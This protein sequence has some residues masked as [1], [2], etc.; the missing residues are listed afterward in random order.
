MKKTIKTFL[1]ALFCMLT[2]STATTSVFAASAGPV[3]KVKSV[4]TTSVT[5]YWTKDSDAKSYEIQRSTDAKNW[6]TIATGIK[7]TEYTDSKSL[8]TGKSYAYRVR[9]KY[10][11]SYSN[12]SS[13]VVG[14]PVPAKVTGVKVKSSNATAIQLTWNK[15]AGASGYT[16]QFLSGSKWKTYKS[17]SSNEI[18]V[19]GVK[20]GTTYSF[21]VAAVKVVSG[22]WIYGPVSD[23]L[24]AA[25]SLPAT[26]TVALGG[27]NSTAMK[28]LWA[29]VSGAKGFEV[30]NH[31]TKEW[32]NAGAKTN[33]IISGLEPGKKYSFSVRAYAGSVK[34]KETSIFTWQTTPTV[35]QNVTITN[36]TTNTISYSWDP[37]EGASGYQPAYFTKANGKW[38]NLPLTAGTNVTVTGLGSMEDCGFRVRAFVK[39]SNVYNIN[40]YAISAYSANKVGKTVLGAT[41]VSAGK[42][43]STTSTN[44]SWKALNGAQSYV[45]E[46]YDISAK[47]WQ[48]YDFN[49]NKWI[50]SDSDDE[51]ALITT[52]ALT[53]TDNGKATRSDVYR[54]RCVDANGNLGTASNEVTASTSDIILGH[55]K[56]AAYFAIEQQLT[57]PAVDDAAS[58]KVLVKNPVVSYEEIDFEASKVTK[59]NGTCKANL[60]L[61]PKSTHSIMVLCTT[62]DGRTTTA[63]SWLTFNIGDLVFVKNTHEYYNTTVNSHLLYAA[64]AINNTKAYEGAVTVKNTT[65]I[66]YDVNYLKIS[67]LE[68]TS[69]KAIASFF[70]M[71]DG[72][73][74]IPL[75]TTE[76]FNTTLVFNKG[77]AINDDGRT[78]RLKSFVEPSSNVS[79]TAYLYNSQN[80]S[81]WK[82]AFSSVTTTKNSD[83]GY[84]MK[85]NFNKETGTCNYHNGFMSTFSSVDFGSASGLSVEKMEIGASALTLTIGPDGI[86][87]SYVASSPYSAVFSASFE[88]EE[89]VNDGGFN[90]DAGDLISMKMGIAGNT[91]FNYTFTK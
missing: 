74:D 62:K 68:L 14:K 59:T 3:I 49:N 66:G 58:Y 64:R 51:D 82:N 46:K 70:N 54:V 52:T 76:D 78:V 71:F 48:R 41:T 18:I 47:E 24:K 80:T 6:T 77:S 87:K 55:E 26:K 31:N 50:S 32:I 27:V 91:K 67:A 2:L 83:G 28:I 34:G 60:Y 9:S 57:W 4:A 19:S 84:T 79:S 5:L 53:F 63:T 85:L 90:F 40:Q 22:K 44:I 45:V 7:T 88:A 12:W 38:I 23:T 36:V 8:T 86:L 89:D 20:L 29:G 81:A 16:V 15:V 37:V 61:A 72:G 35:P 25:P 39:N 17:I 33:I 10:L 43:T 42:S 75:S 13:Y 1:I 30:Y 65:Q 69:P 56:G 11:L 21:R 73:E